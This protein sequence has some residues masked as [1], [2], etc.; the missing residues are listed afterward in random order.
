MV[1]KLY[2]YLQL[3]TKNEVNL[4]HIPSVFSGNTNSTLFF[5][6]SDKI[7]IHRP[8][9]SYPLSYSLVVGVFKYLLL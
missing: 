6:A 8:L 5:L 1:S 3:P 7:V 9:S 2:H 4:S